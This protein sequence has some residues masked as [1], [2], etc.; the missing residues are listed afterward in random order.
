MKRALLE[1][2]GKVVAG[3]A[4]ALAAGVSQAADW[5]TKP[6]YMVVPYPPGGASDFSGRLY[7]DRLGEILGQPVVVDNK[8]GAGGEIG[9]QFVAS[10]KP[11]GYTLLMGAVG[12]HSINSKLPDRRPNYKFPDA[13]NGISMATSTPLAVVVRSSL[14]V[15]NIQ[16][17]IALAKEKP[18]ALTYG[19]AGVGS[20]QHMTGEKFQLETG[21]KLLHVPYKGSGPALTD[22]LGGQVDMVFDT[23][24]TILPHAKSDKLRFLAVTTAE[25]TP[26]LPDTPTLKEEGVANFDLST[27]Y[28]L[29]APAGTPPEILQKISAAMAQVAQMDAVKEALTVQGAIAAPTSPS[30]TDKALANEV[31]VWGD[32]IDRAGLDN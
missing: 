23:M 8:A 27:R 20:S 2:F 18:G 30:D 13:F 25:R 9:A 24:P 7:A 14:P 31:T 12:S 10:A 11:D 26:A 28:A 5:P 21:T 4:L 1:K 29:M 17:L 15:K 6:I 16:E 32:V 19:S 22:L 3:S